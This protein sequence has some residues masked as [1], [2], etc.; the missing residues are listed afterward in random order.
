MRTIRPALAAG[1]WV[2]C[3]RFTDST[4]AYQGY[5]RAFPLAHL[6]ALQR[7]AIGDTAPDLTLILDLPAT[8]GLA[9]ATKRSTADRFETLD[10][11]FHERLRAGFLTIAQAEPERCAVID[12]AADVGSVQR[13]ILASVSARLGV[14]VA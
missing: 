5:G 13:A 11:T 6:T 14:T 12:A 1:R 8:D 4:T 10:L 2:V 9:R 3:D 7:I